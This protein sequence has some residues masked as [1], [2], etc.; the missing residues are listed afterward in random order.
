MK[1]TRLWFLGLAALGLAACQDTLI[2]PTYDDDATPQLSV[3][4]EAERIVP[5][6]VLVRLVDGADPE[7]VAGSHGAAF[8]RSFAGGRLVIFRGAA[9][10][11]R[12]LAA[13]LGGDDR[14]VYAEPDYLR[15]PTAIEPEMWSLYNPGGLSVRY[16]RGRNSGSP[17]PSL[18]SVAGADIDYLANNIEGL[19]ANGS[20]VAIAS[21]DTGVEM[22]HSE[23]GAA[24]VV[25][26]WDFVDNDADPS[27]TNDH[28]THTTGT[29]VGDKVGVAG[30]AGAASNVTVWVY[31]VCG[32]QGCPTSAIVDAIVDATDPAKGIVAMNL[33]L[34]GSSISQ[35]EKDAIA[36]ATAAG[37]LVIAAAGNGSTNTVSCPACDPNAISVAATD[38]LDQQAYYTSYGPGLD[39]SAPGGELYSNTTEEA[40]IYSAVRGGGYAYFQ[41]TSM[42]TPHVTGAAAVIASK[43][44]ATGERLR[45]LLLCNADDRG[46]AG[47]DERFGHGR[48]NLAR[49]LA[50]G[51]ATSCLT[52]GG[53]GGSGGSG[54]G[55][56]GETGDFSFTLSIGKLKGGF[57][58]IRINDWTGYSGSTVDMTVD[59]IGTAD[60]VSKGYIFDT[61]QKGGATYTV[62]VCTNEATPRCVDQ[63]VIF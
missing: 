43:T 16:T 53:S 17:V 49:A 2:S 34:G 5:A 10:N 48:L 39:I 25:P 54:G 55:G 37:A 15:Q 45:E 21:I 56:G 28:G 9:G 19:G 35:S 4:Q 31:R 11:E 62:V 50:S 14:V 3:Q 32:S 8:E 12:A 24:N 51:A 26:G 33:S 40:G 57:N 1:R 30:V 29:M 44:G 61:G 20:S 60:D 13:R 27:D 7:A 18:L 58:A 47:Y 36:A 63:Q 46:D 42:A 52:T 41:G 23:F 59:G 22:T 6:R 38:W